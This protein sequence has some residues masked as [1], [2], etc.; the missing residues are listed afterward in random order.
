MVRLETPYGAKWMLEWHD[1]L[2]VGCRHAAVLCC[3]DLEQVNV[4]E[5]ERFVRQ[6]A[7]TLVLDGFASEGGGD[8]YMRHDYGRILDLRLTDGSGHLL[9]EWVGHT[10]R[11]RQFEEFD[12]AWT[13]AVWRPRGAVQGGGRDPVW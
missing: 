12:F 10:P 1:S 9:V 5:G 3:V 13:S 4:Y 6:E 8:L 11:V 7:G 2:I